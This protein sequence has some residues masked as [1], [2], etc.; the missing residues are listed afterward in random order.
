MSEVLATKAD[1]T[2]RLTLHTDEDAESPRELHTDSNAVSV[3]TVPGSDYLDVDKTGGPLES[4]WQ[5]LVT[6]Y[7][8]GRG[9]GPVARQWAIDVFCRYARLVHA[10]TVH[11]WEPVH[12][13]ISIWYLT[14]ARAEALGIPEPMACILAEIREYESWTDGD[15]YGYTVERRITWHRADRPD[16]T[17]T[18]WET[19]DSSCWGFY[20]RKYAVEAACEA[21][22]VET[23]E[24]ITVQ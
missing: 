23:G 13:P 20:G 12:G 17:M 6:R 11:V 19:T 1:G 2:Y 14:P 8:V 10:A 3:V 21:W 5:R 7:Y 16:V 18:T 4:A 24:T 15:V 22:E 9:G